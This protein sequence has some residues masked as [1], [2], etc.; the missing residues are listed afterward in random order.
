MNIVE[1]IGA[2]ISVPITVSDIE[3]CHSVPTRNSEKTNIV[4]QFRSRAKRDNVLKKAKN[5]RLTNNDLD[6]GSQTAVYVN[7]HLCPTQKRLLAMSVKRKYECNWKSL[8]AS[9]GKIFA[10]QSDGSSKVQI[11]CERD[12]DRVFGARSGDATEQAVGRPLPGALSPTRPVS[13]GGD[14]A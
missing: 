2:A 12:I 13:S 3:A 11:L 7:E 4:I 6:L 14:N 8:W 10:R 1:K 9:N 5:M